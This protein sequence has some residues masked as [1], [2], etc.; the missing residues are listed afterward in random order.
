MIKRTLFGTMFVTQMTY[1]S[2]PNKNEEN[3]DQ[4][5][6]EAS[7]DFEDG[8]DAGVITWRQHLP[9]TSKMPP[10]R[11]LV[12]AVGFLY[13][14]RKTFFAF[15]WSLLQF[16]KTFLAFLGIT[17]PKQSDFMSKIPQIPFI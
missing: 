12:K 17:V 9:Q 3:N 13:I 6:L 8:I 15:N 7:S 11:H 16:L 2:F 1:R 10:P 5:D 14:Y 4:S